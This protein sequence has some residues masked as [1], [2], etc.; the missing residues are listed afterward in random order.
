MTSL[1]QIKMADPVGCGAE[2]NPSMNSL[3]QKKSRPKS[4]D[5]MG[6]TALPG[7]SQAETNLTIDDPTAIAYWGVPV[8]TSKD[9]TKTQET[10]NSYNPMIDS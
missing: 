10:C 8:A 1:I 4:Q 9:D 2:A 5:C 6:K 3:N 7:L